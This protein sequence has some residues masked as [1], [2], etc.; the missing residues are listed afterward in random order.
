VTIIACLA[1]LINS[2]ADTSFDVGFD[3]HRFH[4]LSTRAWKIA[5]R[6]G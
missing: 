6:K 5:H 3:F 4:L 2:A 1:V